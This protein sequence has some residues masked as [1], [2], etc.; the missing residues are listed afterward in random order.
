MD[1]EGSIAAVKKAL[2]ADERV[3]AAL[4]FGSAAKGVARASSDLDVAL[5]ARSKDAAASLQAD[6]LELPGRLTRAGER[7]VHRVLLDRADA[8]LARQAFAGGRMLF[9]REPARIARAL[10]RIPIEYFDGEHHR[11]MR[12]E[13]LERSRTAH[14]G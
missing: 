5:L 11:R 7:E 4:L 14:Q 8:V 3:S 6:F 13:A 9:D 10:E 1:L 2:L 12:A